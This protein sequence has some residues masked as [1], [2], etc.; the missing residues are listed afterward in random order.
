MSAFFFENER[1]C[2]LKYF[3]YPEFLFQHRSEQLIWFGVLSSSSLDKDLSHTDSDW[4]KTSVVETTVGNFYREMGTN[5]L[6]W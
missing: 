4:T 3:H 5:A 2:N 1:R 6:L